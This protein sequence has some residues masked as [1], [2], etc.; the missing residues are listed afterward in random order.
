MSEIREWCRAHDLFLIE[1]AAHAAGSRSAEGNAGALSDAGAFSMLATKV[2]T[3]GGEGGMVTT[4]NKELAHRVTS[5]RFHGEDST[6]GI[7]NRIGYS[8]RMTELQAVVGYFQ[9]KRLE[10]IVSRRMGVA[11]AYD[12]AFVGVSCLS[13]YKTSPGYR[14]G[15]YKYP[16]RLLPPLNRLDVKKKLE[17]SFGIKTGTSYWPPCHLQPAYR[18][19]FSYKEGDFPIAEEVLNQTISLPMYCGLTPEEIG[20]VVTGVLAVC[21]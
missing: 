9:I 18:A 2:I 16:L 13:V 3:S 19:A 7:Q 20:R 21:G 15:Y 14:N 11:Q 12:K 5:L 1:D 10:E 8:W 4:N 6:R 17:E